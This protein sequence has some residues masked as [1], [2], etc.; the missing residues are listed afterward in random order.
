MKKILLPLVLL[1]ILVAVVIGAE[2]RRTRADFVMVHGTDLFTLDPQK[3][4]YQH[5]LRMAKALYEPLALVGPEGEVESAAA[6]A[7]EVSSD[8]LRWT[9]RLRDGLRFS[10]GDPVTSADFEYAWRRGLMPDTAG[11]YSSF[12]WV[13][14]GAR[15]WARWREAALSLHTAPETR[16][17]LVARG[18]VDAEEA[19][20][21]LAETPEETLERTWQRFDDAVGVETPDDSTVIVELER[22]LAYF[23]EYV[24]FMTWSPVHRPTLEAATTV[25]AATGRV[26]EDPGWA[27]AGRLVGNGPYRLERWRYQRDC[28]VEKNPHYW[29]A[30]A[31]PLE[32]IEALVI[33]DPNT[34]I[35][36]FQS[37]DVDWLPDVTADQKSDLL[38]ERVAYDTRHRAAIDRGLAA[39]ES[40]DDI[41]AGLPAPEAGERRDLHPVDAFGTDYFQVYS[42]PTFSDGRPNPLADAR[43]RRALALAIDKRA[44]S[45]RVTRIGERPATTLVPP[46]SVPGYD[47]P[48]GLPFDPDRARRELDAS[49]WV[50]GDDG[51]R[52]DADGNPFPTIEILY[53]TGSPRYRGNS[54]ALRDMWRRELAIPVEVRGRPGKD[55]RERVEK[56]EFMVSRG[57]WFGDYGDPTTFLDMHKTG[58]SNNHR[59]YSNP[60]YDRLLEE[61]AVEADPARRMTLLAEAERIVV[62]E[63]FPV[64]P[65]ATYRTL[66]MYDPTRVRGFT[67]HPRL[68]QHPARWRIVRV[69]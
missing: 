7:W 41:L 10:N 6:E 11:P 24:A 50:R 33:E 57:G 54:L 19:D 69:D 55:Y 29:N 17:E 60:V 25:D 63:D 30:D 61:A 28:R 67:Q 38:A 47:G 35:M 39:G 53:S 27:K 51:V 12:F 62:E 52:R 23:P 9:F 2:D 65:I 45:E 36:A 43:V 20:R 26:R 1:S 48:A 64:I 58:D 16:D 42:A 4:S 49:G 56:G 44:I 13:I 46:T 66:Y 22:P 8:G 3:M 5:D 59:D 14:R 18:L 40:M 68:E 34:A 37:G 21:I 15:D 32:S 31:V